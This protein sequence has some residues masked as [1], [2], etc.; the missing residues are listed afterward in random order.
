MVSDW[1]FGGFDHLWYQILHHKST[2]YVIREL[3]AD[4]L[5]PSTIISVSRTQPYLEDV[6]GS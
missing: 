5:L 2:L 6:Y 1:S 3:Y 4:F